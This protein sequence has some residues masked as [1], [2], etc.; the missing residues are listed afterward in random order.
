M[1]VVVIVF[2]ML[3]MVAIYRVSVLYFYKIKWFFFI[4]VFFFL[5]QQ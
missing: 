4:D 2:F 5:K 3:C 1:I